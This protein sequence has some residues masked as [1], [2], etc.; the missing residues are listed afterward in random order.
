MPGLR[1]LEDG[2]VVKNEPGHEHHSPY[3][4]VGEVGHSGTGQSI[5]GGFDCSLY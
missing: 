4:P 5:L 2:A 3:A 1:S